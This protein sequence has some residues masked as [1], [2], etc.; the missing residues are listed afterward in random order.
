MPVEIIRGIG[1]EMGIRDLTSLMWTSKSMRNKIAGQWYFERQVTEELHFDYA[2]MYLSGNRQDISTVIRLSSQEVA[3]WPESREA[4]FAN[5]QSEA[6][7]YLFA[8]LDWWVGRWGAGVLYFAISNGDTLWNPRLVRQLPKYHRIGSLMNR[9]ITSCHDPKV[10]KQI[11]NAYSMEYPEALHGVKEELI[12]RR[13]VG[14]CMTND[15]PPVLWACSENR[16]DVLKMLAKEDQHGGLLHWQQAD[17]NL[18]TDDKNRWPIIGGYLT[19]LWHKKQSMLLDAWE[20]AFH[21]RDTLGRR[22]P[23]RQAINQDVCVWLLEQKL[24][25]AS[26]LDGISIQHLE[27]AAVLK[28]TRVFRALLTHFRSTLTVKKYQ[29]AVTLALR[30]AARGWAGPLPPRP[31]PFN[32]DPVCPDNHNEIIKILIGA[33][34]GHGP[35]RQNINRK[36]D[37]GLLAQAV[38]T[39]PSNALFLLRKQ[40]ALGLTDYRDVRAALLEALQLQGNGGDRVRIQFFAEIIPSNYKLA[41]D[42]AEV[43]E[44]PVSARLEFEDLLENIFSTMRSSPR[45]SGSLMALAAMGWIR[46]ELTG[47]QGAAE[48]SRAGAASS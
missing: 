14:Y 6:A 40:M 2:R 36:E 15:L 10:M 46:R 19:D 33:V 7:Q 44:S 20:C 22:K 48:M 34:K 38:R 32:N 24:G 12:R 42:P 35:L 8:C 41:C 30:A 9:A 37:R 47:Q 18:I 1:E 16:L 17:L 39:A 27:E 5:D 21:P 28:K 45:N 26:R 23:G 29:R 31:H 13:F 43:N 4:K 25:Y 11:M 3:S